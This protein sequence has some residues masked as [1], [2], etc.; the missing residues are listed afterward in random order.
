MAE[1]SRNIFPAAKNPSQTAMRTT[2][3][4]PLDNVALSRS[5]VLIRFG[6][7]FFYCGKRLLI[8]LRVRPANVIVEH[9]SVNPLRLSEGKNTSVRE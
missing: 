7:G 9:D 4:G 1:I 8:D 6:S 3:F 5:H 2:A